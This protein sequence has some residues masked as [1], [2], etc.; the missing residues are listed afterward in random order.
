MSDTFENGMVTSLQRLASEAG[1]QILKQGGNAVDAAITVCF[2]LN[3]CLPQMC[4]IAGEGRALIKMQGADDPVVVNW[5]GRAPGMSD[6]T[7]TKS[8]RRGVG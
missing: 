7:C 3:V 1:V 6:L 2:A 5:S 8:I 4:C